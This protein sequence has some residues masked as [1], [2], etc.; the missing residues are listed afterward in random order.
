M[1]SFLEG[2]GKGERETLGAICFVG[3]PRQR[4]EAIARENRT[5]PELLID[6]INEK[7]QEAFGD[8]LIDT[9]EGVPVILDEYQGALRTA[10]PN[11]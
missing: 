9:R 5:M 6:G 7:F 4:L 3:E 2:L 1:G 11:L 10:L 8:L